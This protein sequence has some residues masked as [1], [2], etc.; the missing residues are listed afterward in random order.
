MGIPAGEDHQGRMPPW[1]RH[2]LTEVTRSVTMDR[3]RPRLTAPLRSKL[4]L[5][6]MHCSARKIHARALQRVRQIKSL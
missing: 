6:Y 1:L 5:I 3:R 2:D 4:P